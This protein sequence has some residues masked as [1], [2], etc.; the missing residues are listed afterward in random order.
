M[1]KTIVSNKYGKLIDWLIA[2]RLD[3]GLS[4]RALAEKLEVSHTAV[5]RIES[6]ER[7]LDVNEYV[8][9]C[10]ALDIDPHEGINLL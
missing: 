3:S 9:Y 8:I 6:L 10:R 1:Q 2:A 4:I 7:R 5:Q